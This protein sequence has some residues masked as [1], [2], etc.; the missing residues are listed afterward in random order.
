ME[1]SVKEIKCLRE[2]LMKA[3]EILNR[4]GF[5]LDGDA[6]ER[7]AIKKEPTQKEKVN[8]YLEVLSTGKKN[9]KPKHLQKS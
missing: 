5:G 3:N 4:L 6:S 8:N 7:K 2:H 9:S 1:V